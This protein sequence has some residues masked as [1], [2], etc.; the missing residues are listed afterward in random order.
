M[1]EESHSIFASTDGVVLFPWRVGND[2]DNRIKPTDDLSATNRKA[3]PDLLNKAGSLGEMAKRAF[4]LVAAFLALVFF[5]PVLIIVGLLI[6][7]DDPGP[8]FFPH[9]RIGRGGR[10]FL[11]YKFR[12]MTVNADKLLENILAESEAVRNEWGQNQKLKSD[13]RITRFGN[14]LRRTSLDELP[15]LLNVLKGE[16]SLVG[17]R[18]ITA[19]ECRFYGR[20]IGDY[21]SVRPGLTGLWQ[22]SGR[23]QVSYR[24]RVALDVYYTRNRSPKLDLCIMLK[25]VPVVIFGIGQP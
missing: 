21:L 22:V 14:F 5:A 11:C 12:T 24:R 10:E 13:P 9:R 17:P 7:L 16:M 2:G 20:Y 23:S 25:T 15:Q 3:A 4:D 6:F 1:S 8:I 19:G 18:P